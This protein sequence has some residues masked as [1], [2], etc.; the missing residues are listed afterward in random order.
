M[1]KLIVAGIITIFSVITWTCYMHYD[2][3]KFIEELSQEPP[4]KQQVNDTKKDSKQTLVD[5]KGKTTQARQQNTPALIS[6]ETPQDGAQ[7]NETDAGT[8]KGGDDQDHVQTPSD[9]GI[10]PKLIKVFAQ[11]QPI[12]EGMEE[13]VSELA[14]LNRQIYKTMERKEAISSEIKMITDPD[15]GR[16][17]SEEFESLSKLEQEIGTE[18]L[19]LQDKL[20]PLQIELKRILS[21]HGFRSQREFEI[22]H[23]KPGYPNNN[24]LT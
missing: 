12:Y 15:V 16:K 23:I 22:T 7:P 4:P 9:N 6:E 21:E 10:S 11:I 24:I 14:P 2:T 20:V 8:R 1:R 5:D 18:M 19:K 13:I 17:M 3:K